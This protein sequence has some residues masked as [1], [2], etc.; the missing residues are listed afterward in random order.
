MVI[1]ESSQRLANRLVFSNGTVPASRSFN[2]IYI[3]TSK[4]QVLKNKCLDN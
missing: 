4:R 2:D 3:C 1:V